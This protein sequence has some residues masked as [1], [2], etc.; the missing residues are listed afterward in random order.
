MLSQL[1]QAP[2]PVHHW[3]SAYFKDPQRQRHPAKCRAQNTRHYLEDIPDSQQITCTRRTSTIGA[4]LAL[5]PALIP[6]QAA[7]ASIVDEDVATSVFS[8]AAPSVVSVVNFRNDKGVEVQEGIGTGLVWDTNGHIVT[9][10]HCISRLDKS[11]GQVI[12]PIKYRV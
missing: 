7:R 12:S 3:E 8:R 10:Y 11:G 5:T 9:N 1:S 6:V 4:L 2:R